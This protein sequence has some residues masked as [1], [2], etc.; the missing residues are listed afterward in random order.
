MKTF[1]EFLREVP[2]PEFFG[3]EDNK[4]QT[5]VDLDGVLADFVSA[6]EKVLGRKVIITAGAK[7]L[8]NADW[9]AIR[10]DEDFWIAMPFLRSGRK[11]WS[12]IRKQRPF[13]L[14]ALPVSNTEWA[15]EGKLLWIGRNLPEVSKDRIILVERKDKKKFAMNAGRRPNLLIDDNSKNIREWEAAGGMGVLHKSS[16]VDKTIARLKKIGY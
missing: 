5:Y 6:A 10:A 11:L 9:R 15:I 16:A 7:K 4:A 14:S 12:H 3:A 2:E 13:I 8:N 1:R